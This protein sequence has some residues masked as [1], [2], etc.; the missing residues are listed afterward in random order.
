MFF[1]ELAIFFEKTLLNKMSHLLICPLT[2][3]F[4]ASFS[5]DTNLASNLAHSLRAL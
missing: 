1:C 2:N 4:S 3:L 5:I